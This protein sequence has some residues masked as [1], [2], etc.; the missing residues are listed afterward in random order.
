MKP[1]GSGNVRH[2]RALCYCARAHGKEGTDSLYIFER[3]LSSV[4][5]PG[6]YMIK[7]VDSNVTSEERTLAVETTSNTLGGHAKLAKPQRCL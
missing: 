7:A 6:Q 2:E 3:F 4:G 5:I 1:T